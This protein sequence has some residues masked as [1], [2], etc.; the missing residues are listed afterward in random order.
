[1]NKFDFGL[2]RPRKSKASA[3]YNA[4]AQQQGPVDRQALAQNTTNMLLR[5][6]GSRPAPG[7]MGNIQGMAASATG[8]QPPAVQPTGGPGFLRAIN[9]F[10]RR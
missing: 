7:L 5:R 1:M 4:G 6:G 10:K 3:I 8:K 2:F 9:P